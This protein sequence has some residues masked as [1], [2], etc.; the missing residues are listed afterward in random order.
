MTNTGNGGRA[1]RCEEAGVLLMGYLDGELEPGTVRRLEDHLA[2]CVA[3][4]RE[5]RAFR[6]LGRMTQESLDEE[7]QVS[8]AQVWESIYARIERRVGWVLLWIGILILSGYGL[9]QLVGEFLLD[10]DVPLPARLGGGALAAGGLVLLVSF[11]RET[12]AKHGSERYREV[13]R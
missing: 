1:L 12:L 9:W 7:V 13:Q 4:R 3:C 6:D 8:T 10:S 2:V 11:L 5:E